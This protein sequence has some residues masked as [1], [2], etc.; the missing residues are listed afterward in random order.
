MSARVQITFHCSGCSE[1]HDAGS[2]SVRR[3]FRGISG[4]DS[5]LGHWHWEG[6]P[7]FRELF[8]NGWESDPLTGA[9]YCPRCAE[10]IW[11]E[12]QVPEQVGES[13]G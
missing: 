11:P 10:E 5:G 12:D 1:V 6:Q 3:K 7:S 4:G 2:H 9:D 8:P 13:D